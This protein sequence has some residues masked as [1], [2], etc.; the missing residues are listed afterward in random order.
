VP[1][2]RRRT[3]RV[4]R[5]LEVLVRDRLVTRFADWQAGQALAPPAQAFNEAARV[6]DW[7]VEK[8]LTA[9]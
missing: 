3:A 1:A 7:V 2:R 8:W 5:G 6:A 4:V 9:T